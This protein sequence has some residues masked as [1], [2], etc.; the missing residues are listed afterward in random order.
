MF[1]PSEKLHLISLL[2]H[3]LDPTRHST[4]LE[5]EDQRIGKFY[6]IQ[7]TKFESCEKFGRGG[8]E[9]LVKSTDVALMEKR[10]SSRLS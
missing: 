7:I 8:L 4:I 2:C 10:S 5:P 6:A 9:L 1:L 3:I